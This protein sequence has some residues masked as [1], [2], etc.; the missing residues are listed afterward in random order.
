MKKFILSL[1]ISLLFLGCKSVQNVRTSEA[2]DAKMSV[3]QI[4]KNHTEFQS[5]FNTLQG[6]LKVE[7][8]RGDRS[9]CWESN[10]L[11]SW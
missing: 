2:F 10:I 5:K 3:K 6:R 7:L 11:P 8:I 4:V 1:V 9:C